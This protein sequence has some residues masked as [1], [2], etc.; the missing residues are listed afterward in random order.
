LT[1]PPVVLFAFCELSISIASRI[2]LLKSATAAALSCCPAAC[3]LFKTKTEQQQKIS[4]FSINYENQKKIACLDLQVVQ[5]KL[6][7]SN[8][9]ILYVAKITQ[10]TMT[11]IVG[12]KLGIVCKK[13][14]R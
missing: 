4:V 14:E 13:D 7:P 12:K 5:D 3:S 8:L 1:L 11:V 9:L 6:N 2:L 10:N